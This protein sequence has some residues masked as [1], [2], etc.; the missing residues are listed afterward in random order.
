[1]PVIVTLAALAVLV[2]TLSYLRS[3]DFRL[4]RWTHKWGVQH[5]AA[6]AHAEAAGVRIRPVDHPAMGKLRRLAMV[7]SM[8]WPALLVAVAVALLSRGMP[9]WLSSLLLWLILLPQLSPQ[10]V[11][12]Q[13]ANARRFGNTS[14]AL[15][16]GIYAVISWAILLAGVVGIWSAARFAD[17]G[18]SVWH[19]AIQMLSALA[20]L[21]AAGLAT[22]TAK[23]T[24]ATGMPGRFG[25][26][27]T[28]ED[29]LFLRSFNDDAMRF[30]APNPNVGLL[31]VFDGLTVRFEELMAFLVSSESPLVA[32]GK[33]GEPLPE[34]GAVRTY[35]SDEGWQS[36]V[37]E[38]AKRV[39]SI[40]LVAGVTDGLRWELTHL[41]K[42]GLA[43]KATVLLPP[44]DES[45]A[46]NRL[47]RVL[48]QLGIDF[49]QVQQE[50]ETGA[51]LGVLLRTVTA[52]GVDDEG[53]PCF[54]VS[55][56]RDWVSFGAT[57]LM[58]Q[59]I[60]RGSMLPREHGS[61]AEFIGLE[62]RDSALTPVASRRVDPL[63][64]DNM[65]DAARQV[66]TH[67]IELADGANT[68]VKAEHVLVALLA[69]D[70]D[71]SVAL[72]AMGI[73]MPALRSAANE[74]VHHQSD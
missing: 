49:D 27:A 14:A 46:W 43:Q 26:D 64:L 56:R 15:R 55:D 35:V 61:I 52:I 23:R 51:W 3:P 9:W 54:Y 19:W 44:V 28:N 67:A 70:H 20:L 39:D 30:R 68:G 33:P 58:S 63:A 29:T 22:S 73:D 37:E 21:A 18:A 12:E 4:R 50:K 38:T 11:I 16:G 31:G 17:A 57:I 2:N 5:Y 71:A 32:I 48:G 47:H 62:V 74:L 24:L 45:Q 65:S 69:A 41:R 72:H 1:M 6:F 60:V 7:R 13:I 8:A 53:Q 40:I 25:R 66:V 10:S 36:E 34:L 42:W 59:E